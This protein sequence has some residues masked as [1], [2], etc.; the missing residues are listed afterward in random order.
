M[1]TDI[2][3]AQ[4]TIDDEDRA[5]GLAR[6][7]VAARLAAC[8]HVDGPLTAVYRWQDAVETA[9]EW[10]VSYK[11]SSARLPALAEWIGQHHGYEVPEWI[12]LP[13]LDGSPAY[14]EWVAAE[15]AP[16]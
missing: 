9:T 15:S 6:G 13:V 1:A 16:E 10:R 14:L 11:T 7:A 2:V 3:L 4:T 8:A 5:R 12:V